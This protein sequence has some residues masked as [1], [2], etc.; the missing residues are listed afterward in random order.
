LQYLATNETRGSPS[1]MER[2]SRGIRS[3]RS[4]PILDKHIIH[5]YFLLSTFLL[6]EKKSCRTSFSAHS[7][8]RKRVGG[9]ARIDGRAC[10]RVLG[11][12]STTLSHEHRESA[13]RMLTSVPDLV[14]ATGALSSPSGNASCRLRSRWTQIH[15]DCAQPGACSGYAAARVTS[16]DDD[17]ADTARGSKGTP[18]PLVKPRKS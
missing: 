17:I 18:N 6:W 15:H 1:M 4:L 9:A 3:F 7:L 13:V 8:S 5:T 2:I 11:C 12:R 14:S 10:V 16:A